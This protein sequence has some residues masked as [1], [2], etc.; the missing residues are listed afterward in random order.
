LRLPIGVFLA[1]FHTATTT[2]T[3]R[4][5]EKKKKE[6]KRKK[7]RWCKVY[8]GFGNKCAKSPYDEAQKKTGSEVVIF[9]Q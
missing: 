6:L 1:N 4:K 9:R 5:K 7:K 8:K 3:P 2:K